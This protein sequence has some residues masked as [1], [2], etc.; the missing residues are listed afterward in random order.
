MFLS[1]PG[2]RDITFGEPGSNATMAEVLKG[3]DRS[4]NP[5]FAAIN[6]RGEDFGAG[7]VAAYRQNRLVNFT[8]SQDAAMAE[9]T[10]HRI[11]IVQAQTGIVLENPFRSGYFGEASR[12]VDEAGGAGNLQDNRYASIIA[13]QRAVF[14]ERFNEVLTNFPDKAKALDF[15]Q[16][17][18]DQAKAISAAADHDGENHSGGL[19]ASLVGGVAASARDPLQVAALFATGGESVAGTALARIG[20]NA[21]RQGLL[22]AGLSAVEQP[23]VQ[24]WRRDIGVK[25]G[26]V[27]SLENVGMN[28]L[29]G[30][31]IGGAVHGGVE[32]VRADRA[33]LTRVM[34]GT[35][36]AADVEAGARALGV[37]LDPETRAALGMAEADGAHAVT[38]RADLPEGLPAGAGDDIERQAIR[39][40]QD[41]A[42]EAPPALAS[43]PVTKPDI[44]GAAR[45]MDDAVQPLDGVV[46]LRGDPALVE[47]A[48]HASD[49]S[50]RQ[51]GRLAALS[52]EAFDLV[53]SGR[54][55]PGHGVIVSEL[56]PD[57]VLDA[58]V[59]ARLAQAAPET[60]A[61]ARLIAA[62][63]IEG[64]ARRLAAVD[65]A[66][67]A[68][69]AA[70][71]RPT[72]QETIEAHDRAA[73]SP[74]AVEMPDGTRRDALDL[75]PML[76]ERGA[77]AVFHPEDMARMGDQQ[78]GLANLIKGCRLE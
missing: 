19:L 40:A 48:L 1:D 46:A 66:A 4:N 51:A 6:Q 60:A 14:E 29:F 25:N 22:N 74:A 77:P 62:D 11:A 16:S 47:G 17:I 75:V 61:E 70:V 63:A 59:L 27:P 49:P 20:W 64:E 56:S 15:G 35:G 57:P 58:P 5:D 32:L 37:T 21:L 30:A 73:T 67:V 53:Q 43:P 50:L 28:F 44:D 41:P 69:P 36:T 24:E 2:D 68:E 52:D 34:D 18:E 38:A 42:N 71:N 45:A 3:L 54:A 10:D 39:H 8:S 65:A 9:A 78:E 23:A 72:A 33:A 13:Q 76:D 7:V 31:I 12:R 55:D 26:I